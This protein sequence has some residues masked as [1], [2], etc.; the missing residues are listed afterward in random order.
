MSA[1]DLGVG[2]GVWKIARTKLVR[3]RARSGCARDSGS[4]PAAAPAARPPSCRRSPG[5]RASPRRARERTGATRARRATS[6]R[7]P[8]A[9]RRSTNSAYVGRPSIGRVARPRDLG[10]ALA[11]R[12][13]RSDAIARAER[14][15]LGSARSPPASTSP[16]R[17]RSPGRA[18][19]AASRTCRRTPSDVDEE[20]RFHRIAAAAARHGCR[21]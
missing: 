19:R 18:R 10:A 11:A 17:T 2:R 8:L 12:V 21:G 20:A 9:G 6:R 13:E 1:D 3:A 7:G 16:A 15:E 5:P 4:T 14:F